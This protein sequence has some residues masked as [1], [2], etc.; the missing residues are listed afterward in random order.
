MLPLRSIL[1]RGLSV[2]GVLAVA[3]CAASHADPPASPGPAGYL[4]LVGGG[5]RP[6]AVMDRFIE[7]AGGPG[8]A[9]IAVIPT[10]SGN[11]GAAGERLVAEMIE[12]GAAE[13]F[14]L[15]L[16]REQADAAAAA[17]LEGVTGVWF[18]G[19]SQ[20]RI[21]GAL[22]GTP[23]DEKL[24]ALYRDGAVLGGT[25]AGAA[26]MSPIMIT[27]GERR[28]GGD[29]PRDEAWITIDRDN[30]VTTAGLG[31]LPGAIID[32]HF[33]RR[34][35]HNRL[36]SLVLEHPASVGAGIDE[37]T[38][39]VVRPDGVWEVVGESVV[40]IYDARAATISGDRS[41]LGAI[42]LRLHVLPGGSLYDPRTGSAEW[43]PGTDW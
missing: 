10:A 26:I 43:R 5:P 13:S 31:F 28:P 14:S 1:R 16:S 11:A 8:V 6:A 9:R 2:A 35:R 27:G 30:V 20:S 17:E 15:H 33:V 18:G 19:G 12:R 39:L 21:T 38:A 40:V 24:H 3:G 22:G 25:S 37:S 32:Q 36:L 4:V 7:L 41:T 42:G 34:R 29:R 23:V